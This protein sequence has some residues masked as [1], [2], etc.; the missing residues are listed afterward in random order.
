MK[1]VSQFNQP[2]PVHIVITVIITKVFTVNSIIT[3]MTVTTII[4]I[5]TVASDLKLYQARPLCLKKICDSN[6]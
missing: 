5:L 6:R 1:R 2:L 4:L 3:T